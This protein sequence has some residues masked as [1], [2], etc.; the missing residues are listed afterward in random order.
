MSLFWDTF[1]AFLEK[2]G[3]WSINQLLRPRGPP[4]Q[5]HRAREQGKSVLEHAFARKSAQKEVTW[6]FCGVPLPYEPVFGRYNGFSAVSS[7]KR[8]KSG[9]K[10]P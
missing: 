8:R 6:Y 4:K 5:A 10:G 3:K 7:R 2:S 1:P 9:G